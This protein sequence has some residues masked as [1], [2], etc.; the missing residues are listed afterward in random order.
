MMDITLSSINQYGYYIA[1]LGSPEDQNSINQAE[2]LFGIDINFDGIKGALPEGNNIY[3]KLNETAQFEKL[4]FKNFETKSD[5][6]DLYIDNI[7]GDIYLAGS[8]DK[9]N[10]TNIYI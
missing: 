3:E 4:G 5:L 8:N 10:K 9:N 6:T 2:E 7:T 1:D